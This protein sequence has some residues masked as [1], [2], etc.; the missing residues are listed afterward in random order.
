MSGIVTQRFVDP[1]ALIQVASASRTQTAPVVTIAQLD[2]LRIFV[3]APEPSSPFLGAGTQATIEL[4]DLPNEKIES[5]VTRTSEAL[6]PSSRT[7]RVE[8]D[9]ENPKLH[10]RP[11]MT[12]RV[13]LRLRDLYGAVTIPVSAVRTLGNTQTVYLLDG[14]TARAVRVTTGLE[15]PDWIQVAAGLQGGEKVITSAAGEVK[16]GVRVRARS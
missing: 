15:S 13:S 3:D 2:R 11:G 14:D 16:D 1:G 10:L 7:L 9:I 8:V 4:P 12:A 6:D 5:P